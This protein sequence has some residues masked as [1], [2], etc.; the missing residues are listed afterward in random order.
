MWYVVFRGKKM[1]NMV[2]KRILFWS[3]L[4]LF[5]GFVQWDQLKTE[6]EL[7]TENKKLKIELKNTQK[8]LD[9]LFWVIDQKAPYQNGVSVTKFDNGNINVGINT[10]EGFVLYE[11]YGGQIKETKNGKVRNYY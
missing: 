10:E 2:L 9:S 8:K 1:E 5:F 11:I 4:F 3:F 6:A 7:V